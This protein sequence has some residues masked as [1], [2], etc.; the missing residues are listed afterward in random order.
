MGPILIF[1]KST[2]ESLNTDEA[3][4]L[5]NFFLSN[6]TPLFF[7]ETLADL[8]KEVRKGRTPESVVGSLAHRTPD[9]SSKLNAHHRMLLEGELSG[10]GKIDMEYGRPHLSR[11]RVMALGEKTGIMF[12]QS[13]EE[14]ALTRWRGMRFLELER[15]YAKAWREALSSIDFEKTYKAFQAFF[16]IGK[17][18][19]LVD[20]KRVVDVH[21][22]AI[23]QEE[24]LT[25]GLSL[26]GITPRFQTK[27]LD[28]WRS[29]GKP[30]IESFA[31][32]FRHVISVD[33]FFNLAISADLIGRGRPSHK[34]DIAYLYYLPFCMVFTSN[35]NLH[36]D[37]AP[38]FLRE[39][40]SFVLGRDLKEDLA[41]LDTHYDKL[42]P[43]VKDR[44]VMSF[45]HYPPH[46]VAFLVT[47][48]WDKHMSPDWR[49]NDMPT[50]KPD[51]DVGKRIVEEI[52]RFEKE[53][54]PLPDGTP[55]D[56][57]E[58]DFMVV[59]RMVRSRMG[60]WER[61]PPEVRNRRRNA[62][63]EWEDTPD[64]DKQAP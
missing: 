63:G 37:I 33:L 4:W 62:R 13:P 25:F 39:N 12:Q 5:D 45:A 58:A 18:K 10:A 27:I 19:S 54:V 59:K 23:N 40:Q 7:I 22:D 43:E 24:V 56:G 50:P 36:A 29:A 64:V 17:P 60:K 30:A 49:K 2:L 41:K 16:P 11:G 15:L 42:S 35:D 31:P 55:V 47:R 20:V 1:D 8:E 44:G 3:M 32:Y 51:S 46:D 14:E 57:D 26:L 53:G 28:R 61:F 48:L 34:I 6:I 38:L 21:L 9:Q 52:E